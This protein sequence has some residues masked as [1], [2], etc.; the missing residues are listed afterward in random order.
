MSVA[1]ARAIVVSF[2]ALVGCGER[3]EAAPPATAA[4][5]S[6]RERATREVDRYVD[7]EARA[8]GEHAR[9]LCEAED[10]EAMRARWREARVRYERIEGA[11]AILFPQTD[12]D[13]DGRYEHVVELRADTT[14]LDGE[15]FVGMHSIE[16]VL[17]ADEIDEPVLAFESALLHHAP[18]VALDGGNR[19]TFRAGLCA[20]L[21]R[22]VRAMEAELGPVALDPE[23]AWRGVLGSIEEQ[24]E[25]VRLGTTGQSESRY[26]RHTLADMRANLEG[27]R[28]VLGAFRSEIEA[29]PEGPER[30]RRLEEGFARLEQA[31]RALPGDDLPAV[32]D[33]FDPDAPSEAH[34]ATEYG[35]LFALLARESDREPEGSVAREIAETGRALGIAELSR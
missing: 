10:R 1:R 18:A 20:R 24:A 14:P 33:G 4:P 15:G 27:G 2:A 5:V 11:I 31:Y 26:A 21:V 7:A 9:A 25:K 17:W 30:F 28:A 35:R 32:P 6:A 23:T 34:L 22:D 16:R 19:E 29:L 3:G 8:L 13:V 12:Q